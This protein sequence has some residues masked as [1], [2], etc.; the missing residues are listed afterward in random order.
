MDD[1]EAVAAT[2]NTPQGKGKHV[3]DHGE[4][5]SSCFKKKK[6]N[7][8]RRRDDNLVAAV[9]C[10][11]SCPKGNPSKSGLPKDHF[12]KLLGAPC[13]HHEVPVKH[14]PKG[15]RL[16]KNY[17]NSTLKP[18]AV[19]PPKKVALPPNNDDDDAAA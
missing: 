19:D 8:K 17:V 12:E 5:T 1:E 11:A 9:E 14:A 7:D 10:K 4:G 15:C 18:R 3:V 6:K 16:I 13:L 2:L